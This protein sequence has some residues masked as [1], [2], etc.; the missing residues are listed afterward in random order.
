MEIREENHVVIVRCRGRITYREEA[1][2]LADTLAELLPRVARVIVDLSYIEMIDSAGLGELVGLLN[3]ARAC[4]CRLELA[5]PSRRIRSLL[6]LTNLV[7]VFEIY[8]SVRDAVHAVRG[9]V[10]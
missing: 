8:P 4:G 5:A 7:S 9:K 1:A 2:A 10:A 3:R 6:E